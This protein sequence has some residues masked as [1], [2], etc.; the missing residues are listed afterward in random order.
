MIKTYIIFRTDDT[1]APT[2]AN[3]N[4]IPSW[5]A[6]WA[7]ARL[8]LTVGCLCAVVSL[9][10]CSKPPAPKPSPS[11]AEANKNFLELCKKDY[12]LNPKLKF[13][14]N[15]MYIYLPLEHNIISLK[16]TGTPS[17]DDTAEKSRN[18]L[19]LNAEFQNNDFLITYHIEPFKKYAISPGYGS[20]YDEQ[21]RK[22]QQFLLQALTR[23]YNELDQEDAPGD[24]YYHNVRKQETHEETVRFKPVKNSPDFIVV[25]ITDIKKGI[26]IVTTFYYTDYKYI[27]LGRLPTDEY[28]KRIITEPLG[29]I[30]AIGDF[31]GTH[32]TYKDITWPEFIAKQIIHRIK[33]KYQQSGTP[34]TKTDE[35]EI[36]SIVKS[37]IDA[38]NFQDFDNVI[39]KNLADGETTTINKEELENHTE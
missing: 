30:N 23:T 13:L 3:K 21:Y 12:N 31:D 15:T 36:L 38:Y 24:V 4:F 22:K 9:S 28:F 37:A 26:E 20:P 5:P 14:G 34:P 35:E 39:L 6:L 16:A 8:L 19:F 33:F 32:I 11:L 10:G 27:S 7:R 2:R 17:I 1:K 29:N 18:I 25:T